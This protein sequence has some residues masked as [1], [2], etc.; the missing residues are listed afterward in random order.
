MSE[1]EIEVKARCFNPD[2][3]KKKI[4]LD[5]G[6]FL[7]KQTEE[8][9]YFNHPLRDFKK[10]DEAF[11]IRRIADKNILTYKGPKLS[12]PVKSR[13]ETEVQVDNFEKM[14][15]ILL[16]LGFVESG[17]VLK[18]REYLQFRDA[19]VCVDEVEG[20]GTFVEVE[21]LSN[22]TDVAEK[23]ILEYANFLN[24]KKFEKKSY[25]EMICDK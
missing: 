9:L 24:L 8:D 4:L 3:I 15:S 2:K 19:H 25:L 13:I 22:N 5:G 16:S 6:K 7:Y 11:R 20:L 10:T 23:K 1:F 17:A 21:I 18:N 12:S 14:K